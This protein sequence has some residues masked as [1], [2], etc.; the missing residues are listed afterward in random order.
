MYCTKCGG[1]MVREQFRDDLGT[2]FHNIVK[3]WRC[4]TC[5]LRNDRI[6]QSRQMER[7]ESVGTKTQRT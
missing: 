1:L 7:K 5:G 3:D 4:V 6:F 2:L